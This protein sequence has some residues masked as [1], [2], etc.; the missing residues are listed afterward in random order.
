MTRELLNTSF[1]AVLNCRPAAS[2]KVGAEVM[3]ALVTG[4]GGVG[5]GGETCTKPSFVSVVGCG[6]LCRL[7]SSSTITILVNQP[8]LYLIYYKSEYLLDV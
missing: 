8:H 6:L 5:G 2:T 7:G 4:R 1:E 3:L